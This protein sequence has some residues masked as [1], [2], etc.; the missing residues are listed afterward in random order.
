MEGFHLH[1]GNLQST[2]LLH[3]QCFLP[4]GCDAEYLAR[5][6]RHADT[7][8]QTQFDQRLVA[9]FGDRRD[10]AGEFGSEPP[11]EGK[12]SCLVQESQRICVSMEC[13]AS[14]FCHC[15]SSLF[16]EYPRRFSGCDR[17]IQQ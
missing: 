12:A 11:F 13:L 3:W 1:A 8:D 5:E 16:M 7:V 17:D 2:R 4:W 15:P 6:L 10:G 14:G 9:R